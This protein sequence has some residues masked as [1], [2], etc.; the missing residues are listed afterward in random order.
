MWQN[1]LR[2][3]FGLKKEEFESLRKLNNEGF[4][5]LYPNQRTYLMCVIPVVFCTIVRSSVC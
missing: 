5:N 1:L 3:V 4:L 2:F